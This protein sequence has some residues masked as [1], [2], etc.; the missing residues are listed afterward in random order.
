M[1]DRSQG[2][3]DFMADQESRDAESPDERS[4][5]IEGVRVKARNVVERTAAA[6]DGLTSDF[7][8]Q[9]RRA[10]VERKLESD[11]VYSAKLTVW[12]PATDG[13]EQDR[14][15]PEFVCIVYAHDELGAVKATKETAP[16]IQGGKLTSK[17]KKA[18]LSPDATAEQIADDVL[19]EYMAVTSM[20]REA[21]RNRPTGKI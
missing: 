4:E 21:L 12:P 2:L 6:F 20:L 3:S 17:S 16:S 13:G 8:E 5:R 7:G 11:R 15:R 19:S 18:S 10:K 14:P 9:D 1:T